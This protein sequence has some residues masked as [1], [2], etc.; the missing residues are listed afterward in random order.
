MGVEKLAVKCRTSVKTI[1]RARA[2]MV[3]DGFLEL[4]T[5][6]TAPGQAAEYR[7][8]FPDESVVKLSTDEEAADTQE[9][10]MSTEHRTFTDS[11]LFTTKE[12]LKELSAP[13]Q[14]D[15][16]ATTARIVVQTAWDARYPKPTARFPALVAMAQKFLEAGW[17]ETA[18]IAAFSFTAAFTENAIEFQLSRSKRNSSDKQSG[19][20]AVV[21]EL[22]AE[23]LR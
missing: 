8:L 3:E 16:L 20:N 19:A 4:L 10:E 17:D 15:P 21:N 13:K 11:H 18:L 9:P 5:D 22:R 23:A 2:K 7:F 14:T 6:H 1:Q 12:E